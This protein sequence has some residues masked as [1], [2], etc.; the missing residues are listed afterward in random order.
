MHLTFPTFTVTDDIPANGDL[1]IPI[2]P[3]SEHD[4]AIPSFIC[5]GVLLQDEQ[6]TNFGT[7]LAFL[8]NM[9]KGKIAGQD[10]KLADQLFKG[11]VMTRA[12]RKEAYIKLKN[13]LGRKLTR[14]E[15]TNYGDV[16]ESN[17]TYGDKNADENVDAENA[18]DLN[19]IMNQLPDN[20]L[21][22]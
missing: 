8:D 13:A 19:P 11:R 6:L 18:L 12:K 9:L 3:L 14:D 4:W 17:S 5:D 7:R 15:E 16:N 20:Y 21:C 10:R 22:E 1:K 2:K